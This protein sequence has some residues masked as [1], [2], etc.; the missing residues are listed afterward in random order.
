MTS[1]SRAKPSPTRRG[2]DGH[3]VRLALKPVGPATGHVDGA[4][5]PRSRDLGAELPVLT[6]G[7]RERLGRLER[8]TYNLDAWD[9][10]ARKLTIDGG[11]VRAG[12]FR[13]QHHDTVDVIGSGR[14]LTLLVVPPQTS[15]DA[16]RQVLQTAGAAGNAA[17]IEQLLVHT[18][19]SRTAGRP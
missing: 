1:P 15:S 19:G 10:T 5:W 4:W 9:V 2:G 14:R 17:T 11:L 8:I 16:A 18:D 7:L 3:A 6:A 12:G 13:A